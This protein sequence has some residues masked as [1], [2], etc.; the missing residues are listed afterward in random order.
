MNDPKRLLLILAL[1]L[2]LPAACSDDDTTA[3]RRHDAAEALTLHRVV[4][5]DPD[6]TVHLR[7]REQGRRVVA[8]EF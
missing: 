2:V 8:T 6:G 7:E 4:P 5:G 1:V 3:P